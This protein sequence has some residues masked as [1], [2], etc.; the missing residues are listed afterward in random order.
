MREVLAAAIW[1]PVAIGG[2]RWR[3]DIRFLGETKGKSGCFYANSTPKTIKIMVAG[4]ICGKP[5]NIFCHV[6][7]FG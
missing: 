5:Q 7:F 1:A 2:E 6:L 4:S 3:Q